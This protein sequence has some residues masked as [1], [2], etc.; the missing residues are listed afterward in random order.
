MT[1]RPDPLRPGCRRVA[2]AAAPIAAALCLVFASCQGSAKTREIEIPPLQ[3][4]TAADG[5]PG[6]G[7]TL[8]DQVWGIGSG[9][10]EAVDWGQVETEIATRSGGAEQDPAAGAG[11]AATE[12][13]DQD[14]DQALQDAEERRK[15]EARLRIAFGDSI[16]INADGTV[17][18]QYFL[19]ESAAMVFLN[20]LVP[21]GQPAGTV[22]QVGQSFG[23]EARDSVLGRMLGADN[24]VEVI[25]LKDFEPVQNAVPRVNQNNP[26][27]LSGP[28][29]PNSLL[30]V[31]AR[32]EGLTAFERALNQF[33]ANIPQ[34]EIEVKVVEYATSDSV[35][36]GATQFDT[37]TPLLQNLKSGRLIQQISSS[38]P[39]SAPLS[40]QSSITDRGL[41]ALGGIHDSWELNAVLE[42][43]E[44]NNVADV[45]TQPRMV[46]RNG[47]AATV[48]TVTAQPFPKAKISNQTVTT[49]DISFQDVGVIMDIRPEIAG[50]DTV[51]LNIYVSVSAVTGFAATEPVPTPIVST[52]VATTSVHL[53]EGESTVIGGLVSESTVDLE[54]KIPLLGDI[55][56]LGYL[57]RSTSTQRSKNSLEFVITPHILVGSRG[58]R[59]GSGF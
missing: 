36:F 45:K 11:E 25:F 13:G 58:T 37:N 9:P 16:L 48:S 24:Q 27:N 54:A 56:I 3:V 26:A 55:P 57:F 52:R 1:T 30:L 29:K 32:P 22:P 43:L 49:T 28:A 4:R 51:V 59:G 19:S 34:V 47:G 42:V 6:T 38:F 17:T 8:A 20:L 50:T 35:N 2:P 5:Q 44:T 31:S 40:G 18:K 21:F 10:T 12:G 46:V 53:R 39:L 41:I 7:R 15:A 23:G 14:P 33:Y